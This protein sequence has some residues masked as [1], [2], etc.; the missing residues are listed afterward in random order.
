[1]RETGPEETIPKKVL[2]RTT[3]DVQPLL[4]D[5]SAPRTLTV[6]GNEKSP[7]SLTWPVTQCG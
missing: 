6:A 2:A 1:M 5:P 7:P 3:A 4:Q